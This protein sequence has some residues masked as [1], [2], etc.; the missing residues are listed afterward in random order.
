MKVDKAKRNRVIAIAVLVILVVVGLT[1]I[2]VSRPNNKKSDDRYIDSWTGQVVSNPPGKDRDTFGQP[3][4]RPVFL[5]LHELLNQGMTQ[6]QLDSLKDNFYEYSKTLKESIKEVSINV[7]EVTSERKDVNNKTRFF[8]YFE[9]K[10]DRKDIYK[11]TVDYTGLDSVTLILTD[12]FGKEI[13]DSA[14]VELEA[15]D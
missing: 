6:D 5:G 11:A 13:Y 12:S 1:A 14:K 10:F 4:D 3:N 2:I 7:A 15:P 9:V 8:L